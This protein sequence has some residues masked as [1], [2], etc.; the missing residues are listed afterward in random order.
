MGRGLVTWSVETFALT[1][2]LNNKQL[3]MLILTYSN[4]NLY[5]FDVKYLCFFQTN[6]FN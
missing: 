3:K 5:I 4:L 6:N 1:I 2:H